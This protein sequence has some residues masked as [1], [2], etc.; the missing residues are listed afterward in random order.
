[1]LSGYQEVVR[2]IEMDKNERERKPGQ[3]R[4]LK[5]LRVAEKYSAAL[6][7]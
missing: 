2:L 1:L 5:R 6:A 7:P 3:D 4:N